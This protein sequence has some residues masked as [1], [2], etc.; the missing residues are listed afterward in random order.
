MFMLI[1]FKI[2]LIDNA[3]TFFP[4]STR[5]PWLHQV[6]QISSKDDKCGNF[7]I[8]FSNNKTLP[9]VA[10]ASF[11]AS[12]NTALRNLIE[13]ATGIFTGSFYTSP[14]YLSRGNSSTLLKLKIFR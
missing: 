1:L 4:L 11:P 9:T 14:S 5:Y 3:L 7:T 13:G 2:N 10:L 8:K 6:N 12:G